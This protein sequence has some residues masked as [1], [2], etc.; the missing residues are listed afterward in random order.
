MSSYREDPFQQLVGVSWG[1]GA[2]TVEFQKIDH[3]VFPR[4]DF[5]IGYIKAAHNVFPNPASPFLG[6]GPLGI[7]H[8][9]PGELTFNLPGFPGLEVVWYYETSEFSGAPGDPAFKNAYVGIHVPLAFDPLDVQALLDTYFIQWAASDEFEFGD[10]GV[11]VSVETIGPGP[12]PILAYRH[13]DWQPVSGIG[14]EDIPQAL[15]V[16]EVP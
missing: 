4:T 14:T 6:D 13:F 10:A 2:M 7:A 1:G 15:R 12:G 5:E 16:E 9:P 3:S 8:A 11:V